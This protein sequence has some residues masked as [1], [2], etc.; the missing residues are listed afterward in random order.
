MDIRVFLSRVRGVIARQHDR[1][2]AEEVRAHLDLLAAEH[3]RRGLPLQAAR[4]AARRD[5]GGVE[6]MHE[7][8]RDQQGLRVFS[9]VAQDVRHGLRAFRRTP[10]LTSAIVVTLAIGLCA[11]TTVFTLINVVLLKTL[12]VADPERL[13][14]FSVSRDAR[15]ADVSFSYPLFQ[16][17]RDESKM[18]TGI[19]AQ[20]GP[21]RLRLGTDS[22]TSVEMVGAQP[23]SGSFFSTLGVTAAVGRTISESDDVDGP[24]AVL[25]LSD[26]YWA[27]RFGRDSAV[28]GRRVTLDDTPFVVIGVAPPGF[29]GYQVGSTPD[30]WWPIQMLPVVRPEMKGLTQPGNSWLLLMGRLAPGTTR[31]Q[32]QAEMEPVFRNFENDRLRSRPSMTNAQR[33]QFLRARLLLMD[34]RYWLDMVAPAIHTAASGP[35]GSCR[36]IAASGVRQHHESS[37]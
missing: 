35:D 8:Y 23:V 28:I 36:R 10:T 34:G 1:E 13:A 37:A 24:S 12:P 30:L 31:K 5:F 9:E 33:Q 20:G 32:A 16:R 15:E 2:L 4:E 14:L 11:T 25:V 18:L 22:Q 17:F 27:R 21:M 7:A 26:R 29:H 19:S 6:Q 3:E